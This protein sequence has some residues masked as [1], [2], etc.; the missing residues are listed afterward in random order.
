M[1]LVT[2]NFPPSGGT[3]NFSYT[4]G[5]CQGKEN[6]RFAV[7]NESTGWIRL[8][9]ISDEYHISVDGTT[10]TRTGY[11]DA[12]YNNNKCSNN[13]IEVFQQSCECKNYTFEITK[14]I[15]SGGTEEGTVIGTW[16]S[17]G[18]CD[19]SILDT[20]DSDVSI[21]FNNDGEIVLNQS[22]GENTTYEAISFNIVIKK[23]TSICKTLKLVQEF[24]PCDCEHIEYIVEQTAKYFTYS[25][26][27]DVTIA[28]AKTVCG[29]FEISVVKNNMLV[30]GDDKSKGY[31]VSAFT[32][33][34]IK[35]YKVSILPNNDNHDRQLTLNLGF[36][37]NTES[38]YQGCSYNFYLEQSS[39]YN[40]DICSNVTSKIQD[41][42]Y[43]DDYVGP[44]YFSSHLYPTLNLYHNTAI[45]GVDGWNDRLNYDILTYDQT[46]TL[47]YSL[48][49]ATRG[50]GCGYNN[51]L[52]VVKPRIVECGHIDESKIWS[53]GSRTA[54]YLDYDCRR[55]NSATRRDDVKKGYAGL[56]NYNADP[57]ITI[58]HY[59]LTC[60]WGELIISSDTINRYKDSCS[61]ETIQDYELYDNFSYDY[62][63][64]N[65]NSLNE[66][67]L[68]RYVRIG[69][70]LYANG[71]VE[72][73]G[74]I[75]YQRVVQ[76]VSDCKDC[77]RYNGS[78]MFF[79]SY[80]GDTFVYDKSDIDYIL[81]DIALE[82]NTNA[83][84]SEM[85]LPDPEQY[86]ISNITLNVSKDSS[87]AVIG[88]T[89]TVG[90][91]PEESS[92]RVPIYFKI[93]YTD[94]DQ[95]CEF[96]DY[97]ISIW[98]TG[99]DVDPCEGKSCNDIID[100]VR[101]HEVSSTSALCTDVMDRYCDLCFNT[102]YRGSG[103][104]AC[105]YNDFYYGYYAYYLAVRDW[106][107]CGYDFY[108]VKCDEN[109]ENEEILSAYTSCNGIKYKFSN[110]FVEGRGYII[111]SSIDEYDCIQFEYDL[112]QSDS[113]DCYVDFY[114]KVVAYD[115]DGKRLQ[116]CEKGPYRYMGHFG[117]SY[118]ETQCQEPTCPS[119]TIAD[120]KLNPDNTVTVIREDDRDI[121]LYPTT[122]GEFKAAS[123][124]GYNGEP[125]N[126]TNICD[127]YSKLF[128]LTT[129]SQ[130]PGVSSRLERNGY[131]TDVYITV[132]GYSG[133]G[134]AENYDF[135]LVRKGVKEG[136]S[137]IDCSTADNIFITI[138]V[139]KPE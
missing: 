122:G 133:T 59:G 76:R 44:Y 10:A 46:V 85:Y 47:D 112:T 29:E 2:L 98:Q 23:G 75:L 41:P 99:E 62:C 1:A 60:D 124:E 19:T 123:F 66:D 53:I 101:T 18:S 137:T 79:V 90:K 106:N 117:I 111:Y 40:P 61:Q 5:E 72:Y 81:M 108:T 88:L 30:N 107:S 73:C 89:L 121:L 97:T 39:C 3:K 95:E 84:I 57:S 11:I 110:N 93:K 139:P 36:K 51:K 8:S 16:S 82:C 128:E 135:T 126:G 6:V 17:E 94:S 102:S 9:N 131:N 70:D 87:G 38:S 52:I 80:E 118:K 25:G 12:Y 68:G 21:S 27:S 78:Y 45:A 114:Y 77:Y 127:G 67:N 48:R 125:I 7:S 103:W 43:N 14:T 54:E 96:Y 35:Y 129:T 63:K 119:F 71:G 109:G 50:L 26:Y 138:R 15:P 83:Y 65:F 130:V 134:T 116:S 32:D 69:Y 31:G 56:D 64:F 58:D 132:P 120:F 34:D 115:E 24:T 28:S 91:N 104:Q 22:I 49:M 37:K 136:A 74:T 55:F 105:Y 13:R 100:Y 33:G 42:V 4:V 20:S 92:R 86:D 113:V